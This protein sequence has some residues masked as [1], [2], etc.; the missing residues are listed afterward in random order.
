MD[1]A[2]SN[3]NQIQSLFVV[4]KVQFEDYNTA[5]KAYYDAL[6][7]KVRGE[8][9]IKLK[10]IALEELIGVKWETVEKIKASYEESK[11]N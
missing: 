3:K 8:A 5:N 4:N 10:R 11:K 1:A 9:E 2:E 7:S 6:E